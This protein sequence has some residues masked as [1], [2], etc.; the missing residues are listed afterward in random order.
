MLG[1]AEEIRHFQ[2]SPLM[3]AV[4]EQ[5]ALGQVAVRQKQ[6]DQE[7][8][9]QQVKQARQEIRLLHRHLREIQVEML[10]VDFLAQAEVVGRQLQ[11]AMLHQTLLEQEVTDRHLQ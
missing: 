6:V 5:V 2:P 1:L 4:V 8:V 11:A 10:L 9:Q 7:V 3:A